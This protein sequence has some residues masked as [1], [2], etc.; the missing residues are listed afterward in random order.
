[1]YGGGKDCGSKDWES[2]YGECK[3]CGSKDWGCKD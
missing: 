2:M 1:M 3:D